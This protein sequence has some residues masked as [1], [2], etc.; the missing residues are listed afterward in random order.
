LVGGKLGKCKDPGSCELSYDYRD[1]EADAVLG[2]FNYS[3]FV[4]GGTNGKGH[5]IGFTY[6][7]AKN[8]QGALTYFLDDKGNDNHRYDRLQVDL[9]LKF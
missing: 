3:D 1:L 9:V 4:G 6:Q 8:T 5:L 2:A 7:L